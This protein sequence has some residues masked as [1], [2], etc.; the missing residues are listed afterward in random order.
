MQIIPNY[1]T[2]LMKKFQQICSPIKWKNSSFNIWIPLSIPKSGHK[3]LQKNSTKVRDSAVVFVSFP[4]IN[5]IITDKTY[6]CHRQPSILKEIF[7]FNVLMQE[8]L[9]SRLYVCVCFFFPNKIKDPYIPVSILLNSFFFV[10]LSPF[11]GHILLHFPF[12]LGQTCF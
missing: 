2:Y 1:V 7:I 9:T 12:F 4:D 5:Q 8:M 10:L 6:S 3:E 11:M